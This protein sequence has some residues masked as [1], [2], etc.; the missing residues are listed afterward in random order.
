MR[1]EPL[2]NGAVPGTRDP[3]CLLFLLLCAA[4]VL[5]LAALGRSAEYDEQY[6]L[7]LTGQVARPIWSAD[8]LTA[9]DVVALQ[10][11][12]LDPLGLA[13]ALRTT[14]VHPPLYF[15]AISAWRAL[16][17]IDPRFLSV[18]CALAAL[19]LAGHLA[20]RLGASAV[21]AMALTLGCYGFVYTG[22]IARGFAPATLALLVGAAALT[23]P[24]RAHPLLAGLAFGIASGVNYLA[25]FAAAGFVLGH[26]RRMATSAW[27]GAGMAPFILLD[28]GFFLAQRNA[29]PD[30]FPPFD[31]AASAIRLGRYLVATVFGGL[32]LYVGDGAGPVAAAVI[33]ALFIALAGLVAWH[34][35]QAL[36]RPPS[37]TSA[38]PIAHPGD[39]ARLLTALAGASIAQP[40]GLL[41]LGIVFNNTPIELRYLAFAVPFAMVLVAS[42]LGALA[43]PARRGMVAVIL[44]VQAISMAGLIIA[45]QTMQPARATARSAAAMVKDGVVLVPHGNDGVGIVGAFAREA[46]PGLRVMIVRAT[47][48]V[49]VIRDRLAA[50]P[51]VVIAA[52]EQDANSRATVPILRAALADPCWRP[53]QAGPNTA[54][55]DRVC[56]RR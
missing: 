19:V 44:A 51:R 43:R 34:L 45:P 53:V 7:F 40:L 24:G 50:Q 20:S 27:V 55:F 49:H 22:V 13:Q 42:A 33:G 2:V 9:G 18:L 11:P 3:R 37:P 21:V 10:S 8:I 12:V 25:V 36:V 39:R 26:A 15:W 6:T 23:R 54:A 4:P 46:P 52:M 47:D 31:L 17:P 28:L 14:D 41:I 30:Q 16:L 56:D 48:S 35:W 29:R 1:S 38:D 32:P 5:V